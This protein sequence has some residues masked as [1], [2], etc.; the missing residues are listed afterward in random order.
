MAL[1]DHA[2]LLGPYATFDY[3]GHSFT[4]E[5]NPFEGET[6]HPGP[7]RLG[8]KVEEANTYRIGHP[9]AQRIL[10]QCKTFATDTKAVR[11]D[12]RNSG[13]RIAVIEDMV[14]KAGWLLCS[15]DI[16]FKRRRL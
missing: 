12:Y 16:S 3:G 4:L 5:R 6:I 15:V 13:K 1:A 10:G 7:Y 14:G 11:F 8:K 9:L 2:L